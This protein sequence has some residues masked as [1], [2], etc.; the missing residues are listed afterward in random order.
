MTSERLRQFIHPHLLPRSNLR[1]SVPYFP[2]NSMKAERPNTSTENEPA[3]SV[4]R[5]KWTLVPKGSFRLGA[6]I[7]SLQ[8]GTRTSKSRDKVRC[9]INK[10][11]FDGSPGLVQTNVGQRYVF[12][13]KGG[14]NKN[15]FQMINRDD[16]T[17]VFD[18]VPECEPCL[19]TGIHKRV[20]SVYDVRCA[21]MY[22]VREEPGRGWRR[23]QRELRVYEE[24]EENAE[25][26]VMRI[27]PSAWRKSVDLSREVGGDW[28]ATFEKKENKRGN[29]RRNGM[30]AFHITVANRA[31]V[32]EA[33]IFAVCFDY[34]STTEISSC[35]S[36]C[37]GDCPT[38]G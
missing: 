7:S 29:G 15:S 16:G 30:A 5:S 22:K 17:V 9:K 20:L 19:R 32:A 3:G 34:F 14:C 38:I 4:T 35:H 36:R 25:I 28:V 27:Q 12:L 13:Q 26:P 21:V 8:K 10:A 23:W 33:A 11:S 1:V 6:C 24:V 18:V 37:G 31:N 2:N